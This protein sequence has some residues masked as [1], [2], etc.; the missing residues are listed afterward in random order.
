MLVLRGSEILQILTTAGDRRGSH[1]TGQPPAAA[2]VDSAEGAEI[3][4]RPRESAP[5]PTAE[6][7]D[8]RALYESARDTLGLERVLQ[9]AAAGQPARERADD[10]ADP[11][12]ERADRRGAQRS[13]PRGVELIAEIRCDAET[14]ADGPVQILADR[15]SRYRSGR[16]T[17]DLDAELLAVELFSLAVGDLSDLDGSVDDGRNSR[18]LGDGDTDD[19]PTLGGG[20]DPDAL[21]HV[22]L[23]GGCAEPE[24]EIG[25][26]LLRRLGRTGEKYPSPAYGGGFDGGCGR[27]E[28]PGHGDF[29]G[30]PGEGDDDRQLYRLDLGAHTEGGI[31]E[32]LDVG[33]EGFQRLI[34]GTQFVESRAHLCARRTIEVSGHGGAFRHID[35]A[36]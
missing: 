26:G 34:P 15:A 17:E 18:A 9:A 25:D 29:H 10:S 30:E 28:Q 4:R 33:G 19:A 22:L 35:L 5:E 7:T 36:Q 13:T 6:T 14:L 16:A 21:P 31:G 1:T 2:V 8:E 3:H 23:G 12:G 11:V 20:R 32:F 24:G 27:R